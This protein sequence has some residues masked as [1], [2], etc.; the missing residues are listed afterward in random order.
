M[1]LAHFYTYEIEAVLFNL[2]L[3]TKYGVRK[4]F[5][6]VKYVTKTFE[7]I[8]INKLPNRAIT[9]YNFYSHSIKVLIK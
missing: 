6:C 4:E 9:I 1:L 2:F 3:L 5:D 8:C 7:F